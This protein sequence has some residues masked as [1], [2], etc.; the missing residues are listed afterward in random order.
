M[1]QTIRLHGDV[2]RHRAKLLIDQAPAGAVVKVSPPVRTSEQNA[3]MW[4]MLSD[5]ARAKPEGRALPAETWKALF[6]SEC[7]HQPLFEPALD[8]RGVVHVGFRSSRLRVA[9][10][11]D[12]I[13]AIYVYGAEH[14]VEWSEPRPVGEA[15]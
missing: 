12:L 5:V 6:M 3:R 7:G 4:A 14:G 1:S 15:A 9:E 13:E 2:Q 10:M 11:S 8:G